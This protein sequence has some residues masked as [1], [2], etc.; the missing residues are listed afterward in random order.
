MPEP[1]LLR[2]PISG[3]EEESFLLEVSPNGALPLDLKLVG[4][5]G[6]AVFMFKLRHKRVDECKA[7]NRHCTEDEWTQIL[8]QTLV[9]QDPVSG[10]EVRADVHSEKD[11]VTLSFRKNIEGITQRLG[12]VKLDESSDKIAVDPFGWCVSA[13]AAKAKVEKTLAAS[14]TKVES[15]ESSVKELKTQLDELI[16]AKEEDETQML[17]KFRDLLNEKKVM[18]RQQQRLLASANIDSAK[19][20]SVGEGSPTH[21]R[22]A[23]NSRTSKRKADLKE[24]SEDDDIQIM[25]IDDIRAVDD[26]DNT[27]SDADR[28]ERQTTDDDTQS[29]DISDDDPAPP[30]PKPRAKNGSSPG[31]KRNSAARIEVAAPMSLDPPLDDDDAAPPRRNLPFMKAKDKKSTP[32]TKP[33]DDDETESDNEL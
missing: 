3:H 25:D 2:F 9:N 6:T 29:E 18:I 8:I 27:Q 22:A 11:F 28:G 21:R 32:P 15:L 5:E 1:T 16:E 12:S 30:A 24:E 23:G 7:S 13:L 17:E 14:S 20:G 10:I 33:V 4:S 19:L 31:R 26:A